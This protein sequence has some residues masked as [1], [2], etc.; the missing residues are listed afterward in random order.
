M[1]LWREGNNAGN[2]FA[3]GCSTPGDET[4][5][6]AVSAYLSEGAVLVYERRN[7]DEI[8]VVEVDGQ[9]VG[10]GGD[11]GGDGAWAVVL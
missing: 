6:G 4:I 2:G 10:I 9:Y 5:D 8:A 7:S 11:A 3:P 1:R